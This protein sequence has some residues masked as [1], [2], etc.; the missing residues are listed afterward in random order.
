MPTVVTLHVAQC[1][2]VAG[3]EYHQQRCRFLKHCKIGR[4]RDSNCDLSFAKPF[5]INE[6][7]LIAFQSFKVTTHSEY[8]YG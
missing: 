6:S 2:A 5:V 8:F 4:V 3:I 1:Q 7:L